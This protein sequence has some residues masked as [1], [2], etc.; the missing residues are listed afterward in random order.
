MP[1][2]LCVNKPTIEN[3]INVQIQIQEH[4]NSQFAEEKA[5]RLMA[6]QVRVAH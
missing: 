2:T 5:Q 1:G 3:S 4:H 6:T